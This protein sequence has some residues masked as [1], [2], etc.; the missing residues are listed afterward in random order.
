MMIKYLVDN[1]GID[2]DKQDLNLVGDLIKGRSD[3]NK[4]F[5][6]FNEEKPWLWDIIANKRNSID[7]DKFDY[8]KR[9]AYNCGVHFEFNY[10][11]A[12]NSCKVVDDQLCYNHKDENVLWRLFQS[13]HKMFKDVYTHRVCQAIDLM[14][15]DALIEANPK[16]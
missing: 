9:D 16:Y 15:S 5:A 6:P 2:I 7:V 11:N 13:R 8:L 1:N 12:F 3:E 10:Q 4:M 14:V